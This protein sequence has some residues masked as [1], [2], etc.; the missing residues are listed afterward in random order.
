MQTET[1]L[2]MGKSFIRN[3]GRLILFNFPD[4][5][6][7]GDYVRAMYII[8]TPGSSSIHTGTYDARMGGSGLDIREA[9]LMDRIVAL[10]IWK[11]YNRGKLSQSVVV[12]MIQERWDTTKEF[13]IQH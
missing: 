8:T 6:D 2:L 7:V 13:F 9:K 3:D 1:K 10:N 5:P 12:K 4:Q 11:A